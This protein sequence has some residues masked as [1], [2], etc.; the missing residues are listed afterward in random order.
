[1]KTHLLK[2]TERQLTYRITP[3]TRHR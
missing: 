2:A 1:M 3:A